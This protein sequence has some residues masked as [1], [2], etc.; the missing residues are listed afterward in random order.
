MKKS[1]KRFG[2]PCREM[3][4]K[5]PAVDD[6][7]TVDGTDNGTA[8]ATDNRAVDDATAVDNNGSKVNDVSFTDNGSL[9]DNGS[10]VD[11][12]T[13]V[14]N[15]SFVDDSHMDDGEDDDVMAAGFADDDDD[16]AGFAGDDDAK[17]E[18][19]QPQQG[20]LALFYAEDDELSVAPIVATQFQATEPHVTPT[21]A[22]DD[23][24]GM[25]FVA[26]NDDDDNADTARAGLAKFYAQTVKS[27]QDDESS[28]GS[29]INVEGAQ[30]AP[31]QPSMGLEAEESIETAASTGSAYS[32]A[33]DDEADDEQEDEDELSFLTAQEEELS[34][35]TAQEE[36]FFDAVGLPQEHMHFCF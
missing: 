6:Y 26:E 34:F 17:S 9:A 3:Q 7:N 28:E 18:A 8:D 23:N 4:Q 24:G 29:S 2:R 20:R 22:T 32:V 12:I 21:V 25:G 36:E 14:D 13:A 1:C 19:S 30:S 5:P 15:L 35:H 31:E 27:T 16:M 11:D 33:G 10:I